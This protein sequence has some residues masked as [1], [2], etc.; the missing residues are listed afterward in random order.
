MGARAVLYMNIIC[1]I[2]RD[3]TSKYRRLPMTQRDNGE[4]T[5]HDELHQMNGKLQKTL[6]ENKPYGR[7]EGLYGDQLSKKSMQLASLNLMLIRYTK[8]SLQVQYINGIISLT[9]IHLC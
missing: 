4:P 5:L 8:N 7:L 3:P 9:I 6:Y 2:F 1:Q